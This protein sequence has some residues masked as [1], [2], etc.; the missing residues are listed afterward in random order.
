MWRRCLSIC[1]LAR[2][3]SGRHRPAHLRSAAQAD[4]GGDRPAARHDGRVRPLSRAA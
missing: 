3:A 2:G 4:G 1:D